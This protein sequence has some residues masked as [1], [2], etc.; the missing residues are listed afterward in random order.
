MR[1]G[2]FFP[3]SKIAWFLLAP[4]HL[5]VWLVMATV[6]LLCWG[7]MRAGRGLALVSAVLMVTLAVLPVGRWL[8]RPLED[9]YPRPAVPPAKVDGILTLG[10]GL[11]TDVLLARRAPGTAPSETRLVSTFE[12]ARRY[13]SAR[14]VFSGGWGPYADAKAAGYI[15]GQMGLDPRR[16]TL[17]DRSRNTFENLLFTQRLVRPRPGEVW[18]LATSAVQMPRAMAVARRLG[19]TMIPWPTD[20]VTAPPGAGGDSGVA[21]NLG[22]LDEATHEW[23]GLLAYQ[24]SGMARPPPS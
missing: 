18:L 22:K 7:R 10:G 11:E 19:W 2:L 21:G 1:A 3:V 20:Y 17:E 23:V 6:A 14:V 24:L 4:S 16:L 12:L 13:P 5:L 9:Q 8:L 15:F